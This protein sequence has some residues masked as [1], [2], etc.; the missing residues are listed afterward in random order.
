[1]G[2]AA[3][4]ADADELGLAVTSPT[5]NGT[6]QFSTD[7]T[8]GSDGTWT[9]FGSSTP[10]NALLLSNASW[11]R[12]APDTVNGETATLTFHAWD[13]TTGTASSTGS[14]STGNPASGGGTSS[15]SSSTAQANL[16]VTEVNDAPTITL[17]P[18]VLELLEDVDTSSPTVVATISI[19]DDSIGT[20]TLSLSGSDAGLFDIVGGDLRLIAGASLDFES[21]PA[22][23]VT[24]EVD[25]TSVGAM[26]DD[27][28]SHSVTI[29][30]INE[31]PSISL[32]SIVSTMPENTDTSS[33]ILVAT[34]AI[35]DDA[36]GTNVLSLSG[37]DASLFELLAGD[38]ELHLRA[39][40]SLD[41]LSNPSLDVTISVEDS[42]LAGSPDDAHPYSITV[43]EVNSPATI[44][45][46]P[47]LSMLSEGADTTNSIKVADITVT[48]DG[49]GTNIVSLSGA[50]QSLFELRAGDTELHL[51]AGVGLDFETNPTLDVT[52]Q[53]DDALVVGSP[54]DFEIFS[55]NL[56]DA[57]DAPTITLTSL[58]NTLPEDADTTSPLVVATVNVLDDAIGSNTIS[59]SGADAHLFELNGNDLRL[60]SGAILDYETNPTLDVSVNVDDSGIAGAP[61]DSAI[62][63]ISVADA[64][65]APTLKVSPV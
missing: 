25:D 36:I 47:I 57:N 32:T 9:D 4:D 41:F 65:D 15:Y 56:I 51:R 29:R 58:V 26:P 5:G 16:I 50:D 13:G 20:N 52:V 54:D 18:T 17:T 35:V 55:M 31:A 11:V 42:A 27:S 23:D 34:L 43:T 40:V 1:M 63:S 6:W 61:E 37:V 28:A 22:L 53:V 48:D 44:S 49:T 12:Y 45:L 59:L 19:E 60:A 10:S 8:D 7:S 33:S 46:T 2:I 62:Q 38:T 39:G 14:P 3:S 64:N 21:N 24:V 30:D